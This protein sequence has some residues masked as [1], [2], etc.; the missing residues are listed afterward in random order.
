MSPN[1]NWR[2]ISLCCK[3]GVASGR[4]RLPKEYLDTA[5][6]F[7][8]KI[9]QGA[10]PGIDGHLPGEKVA[11]DTSNTR[12]IPK[13]TDALSPAPI[14]FLSWFEGVLL[15]PT[16]NTI[17]RVLLLYL[18]LVVTS[19]DSNIPI[20]VEYGRVFGNMLLK[21]RG[22]MI[23]LH[24]MT[25]MLE[26]RGPERDKIARELGLKG[27]VQWILRIGYLKSYPD[28]VSLRMPISWFV[29]T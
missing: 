20:L 8:I 10:K 7:D 15:N 9:G 3:K 17:N 2:N 12:M 27:E 28:P 4:F 13:G 23:A 26:E 14:D 24:P 1:S 16:Q 5:A 19:S 22:K 11:E 6:A 18:W 29:Q 25:Q 21:I